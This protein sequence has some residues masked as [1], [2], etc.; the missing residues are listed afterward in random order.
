MKFI[1][2][3]KNLFEKIKGFVQ[4]LF[5][6]V[7]DFARKNSGIAVTVV[8]NIKWAVNHP[9][10]D[11][12]TALIPGDVDNQVVRTL[13]R[14]LPK[15]AFKLALAHRIVNENDTNTDVIEA[16]INYLKDA[17][18]EA[19]TSFYVMFAAELNLALPDGKIT[20]SEAI[21]LSQIAYNEL[22]AKK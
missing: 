5:Q 10:A 12:I 19:K 9:Y 17:H 2:L 3:M 18:P 20:I 4:N 15:V 6:T 8:E 7:F 21:I 22:I 14:V 16:I 1:E 11:I 13:R